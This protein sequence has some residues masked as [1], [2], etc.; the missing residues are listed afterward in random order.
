[1]SLIY[2]IYYASKTWALYRGAAETQAVWRL[3]QS[4]SPPS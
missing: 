4:Y 3:P 2:L 1:M